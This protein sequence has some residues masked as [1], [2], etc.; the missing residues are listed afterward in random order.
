[1]PDCP[2]HNCGMV[3]RQTQYGVRW[4][5]RIP[6]CTVVCWDGS[7]ST[8]ADAETRTARH[9]AHDA[10]DSL[11]RGRSAPWTRKEAYQWLACVL[12]KPQ[13][14]AHIG[15]CNQA[16]CERIIRAVACLKAD[17]RRD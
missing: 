6:G 14:Q 7:T 10:F 13:E 2:T 17:A 12:G 11:Y 15:M 9:A 4:Q 1:M 3:A 16:E 5:C 8:P